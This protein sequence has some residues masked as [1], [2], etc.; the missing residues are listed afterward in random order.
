MT[1][2]S[3]LATDTCGV[4]SGPTGVFSFEGLVTAGY[5]TSKGSPASNILYRFDNCSQTVRYPPFSL[6]SMLMPA[7]PYSPMSITHRRQSRSPMMMLKAS[8]RDLHPFA[9]S[10]LIVSC[11]L[12]RLVHQSEGTQRIRHV[13]RCR[14]LQGHPPEFD[15]CCDV[16]S[17]SLNLT[18]F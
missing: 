13:A 11:S 10:L 5:L 4:T 18:I 14:G 6:L 7:V 12:E 1:L 2:F 3:R 17:G 15:Y 16:N 8:V 9:G